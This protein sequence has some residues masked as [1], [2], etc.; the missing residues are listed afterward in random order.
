MVRGP[1][2][3]MSAW[4]EPRLAVSLPTLKF[5]GEGGVIPMV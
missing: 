5:F 1:D 2:G 3:P 4:F